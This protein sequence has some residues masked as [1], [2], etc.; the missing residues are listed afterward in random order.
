MLPGLVRC[1]SPTG[2]AVASTAT[3]SGLAHYLC[4]SEIE[5]LGV[6]SFG[7]ENVGRLDVPMDDAFGVSR[8]ER[9]GNL[10]AYVEERVHFHRAT[11]NQVLQGYPVQ[12]LHGDERLTVLFANFVDGADVGMVQGG[13]SLG[14]ALKARECLRVSATSSGRNLRATKRPSSCVLGLVDDTHPATAEFLD[15]TVVRDGLADHGWRRLRMQC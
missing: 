9:V 13:C 4:Q 12:K 8:V 3:A 1:S 14:F 2:V 5:N 7:D 15:D 10:D 6:S 11:A